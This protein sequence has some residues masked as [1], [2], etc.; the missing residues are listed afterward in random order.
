M[1][2][3]AGLTRES[4]AAPFERVQISLLTDR[5]NGEDFP[6]YEG[7]FFYVESVDLP[8]RIAF[9]GR[10]ESQSVGLSS[11]FQINMPFSGFKL[12]HDDY[13]AGN[14][15]RSLSLYTS[16]SPRAINQFVN[17]AV[18]SVIP[19]RSFLNSVANSYYAFYPLFP[20]QR[21]LSSDILLGFFITGQVNPPYIYSNVNFTDF[22]G[23]IIGSTPMI[24]N[25]KNYNKGSFSSAK[26]IQTF[27]DG[28][29]NFYFM[30]TLKNLTIPN[31]AVELFYSVNFY[32][33]PFPASVSTE[34]H[35]ITVS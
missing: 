15:P 7:E 3:T 8:C 17:P 2:Y 20:R 28:S 29:S 24:R 10:D 6:Q 23:A 16:R 32:A 34:N 13:S 19:Y 1:K 27:T 14:K 5:T 30:E 35:S 22:D 11:G 26:I 4:G 33:S 9:N 25:N 21:F 31:G 12:F 18:Q